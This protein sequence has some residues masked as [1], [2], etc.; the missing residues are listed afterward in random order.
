MCI[1]LI[2]VEKRY[3]PD[4]VALRVPRLAAVRGDELCVV[5]ASGTGKT[6]LLHVLGGVLLPDRG[7]VLVDGTDITRLTEAER[8]RFRAR[9][10]GYVFQI[11]HLL[12]TYT[13][14]ENVMLPQ[15]FAGVPA[16]EARRRAHELLAR[17]GLA[18]HLKRRPETLSVGEQQRV[19]IARAVACRPRLLLADEPTA[20]L[21][22]GH[23][24][25]TIRLLR[26]AAKEAASVLVIVTHDE[27][28]RAKFQ[29]VERLEKPR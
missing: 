15:H 28:V 17:L 6:T 8:D 27:R 20:S 1:E 18:A 16:P 4:E 12:S 22:T 7:Q 13:V 23:A 5:G 3:R 19:A 14:L 29:R 10:V 21:D 9:S 25:E 11:F 2:D 26:E 24:D